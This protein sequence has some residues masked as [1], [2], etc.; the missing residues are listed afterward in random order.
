[1]RSIIKKGLICLWLILIIQL[2]FVSAYIDPGTGGM[3]VTSTWSIILTIFLIIGVFFMKI[4]FKPIK[5]AVLSIW[6]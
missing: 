4:I 5:K 6:K 1:M 3:I 2:T